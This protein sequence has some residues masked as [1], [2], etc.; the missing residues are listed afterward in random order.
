MTY[1]FSR[2]TGESSIPIE[3]FAH[4]VQHKLDNMTENYLI[5]A[6][7]QFKNGIKIDRI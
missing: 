5:S 6:R 4:P 3:N 2:F 1:T 7:L